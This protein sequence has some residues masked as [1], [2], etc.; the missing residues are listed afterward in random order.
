MPTIVSQFEFLVLK[1]IAALTK[2][3]GRIRFQ[4]ENGTK[5]NK[6]W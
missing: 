6:P 3:L 5:W 2:Q 1:V 4:D